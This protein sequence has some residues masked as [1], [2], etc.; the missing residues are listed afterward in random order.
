M[1]RLYELAKEMGI[2][3]KKLVLVIN[4]LRTDQ[5]P[6]ITDQLMNTTSADLIIGL[7]ED[8]EL[9]RLAEEGIELQSLSETNPVHKKI[10]EMMQK[11]G[12]I[13]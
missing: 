1:V 6:A 5:L 12:I 2:K 4:R 3:Y 9:S 10:D 13:K 7:P 8:D 11:L